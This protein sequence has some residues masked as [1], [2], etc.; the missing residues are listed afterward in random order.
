[1]ANFNTH[2]KVSTIASGSMATTIAAIE[3]VPKEHSIIL[4]ILGAVAGFLPDIDSDTSISL[5]IFA[6]SSAIILS[7]IAIFLAIEHFPIIHLVVLSII[8]YYASKFLIC[9]GLKNLTR[10]R[11]VFH[12]VTMGVLISFLTTILFFNLFGYSSFYS[13]LAGWFIFVG[14]ISHL[15][16]DEIYSVNL[17]GMRIKKSFGTALKFYDKKNIITSFLVIFLT[18]ISFVFTPK[19]ENFLKVITNDILYKKIYYKLYK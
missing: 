2:F 19:M 5:K 11:G 6:K 14:Y 9:E 16:L 3:L 12:T 18:A 7:F 8:T 1:M 15:I 10:H 17:Y 13:W 4:F